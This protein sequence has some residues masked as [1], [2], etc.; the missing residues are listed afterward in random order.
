MAP[1]RVLS[2]DGGG[3]RGLLSIVMLEELDARV[4]GW[5]DRVDLLAGTSTGGLI[6]LGLAKVLSLHELH[7]IYREEARK[8]F[9]DSLVDNLLDLGRI[10]GAE[11]GIKPLRA[12]AERILG[13]TRLQDLHKRV[14]IPCFDLDNEASPPATRQWKPKFFHNLPGNDTDGEFRAADVAVSWLRTQWT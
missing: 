7:T 2:L 8:V 3:V 10:V 14:L 1:Y 13:R 6:A 11:Y 9:E 4:P 5:L 12:Q